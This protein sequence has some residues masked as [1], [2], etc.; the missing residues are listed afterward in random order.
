MRTQHLRRVGFLGVAMAMAVVIAMASAPAAWAEVIVYNQAAHANSRT[1]EGPGGGTQNFSFGL[2]AGGGG[3]QNGFAGIA[4]FQLPDVLTASNVQSADLQFTLSALGNNVLGNLDIYG[5]GF[6]HGT[7]STTVPSSWYFD[8]ANDTRTGTVLGTNIGANQ[9]TKIADNALPGGATNAS[10]SVHNTGPGQD[11]TLATFLRSLYTAGA[12]G[13]DYAIIRFN[14]DNYVQHAGNQNR[15]N[16]G[17]TTS[18]ATPP[19]EVAVLTINTDT[20]TLIDHNNIT[21]VASSQWTTTTPNRLASQAVD[22]SGLSGPVLK[23]ALHAGSPAT[24][25]LSGNG[26]VPADQWFRVD[27]GDVY[28]ME[29]MK[30]FND[31]LTTRQVTQADIYTAISAFD[32]GGDPGNPDDNPGNWVL[33]FSNRAFAPYTNNTDSTD[34]LDLSGITARYVALSIDANGGDGLVG[35]GEL[36]FFGTVAIP[37]PSTAL[38]AVTGI[39]ALAH[40]RSRR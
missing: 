27:L 13:G 15:Y 6:L 32:H 12:V 21:A 23:G 20:P 16:I 34:I 37:E 2:L 36:Q 7:P 25:W 39:M 5:L 9:V 1:I 26:T 10:P 28:K 29:A 19:S 38:L 18:G 8:G 3:G 14:V 4:Y 40:R 17:S 33:Q 35:L 11:A 31:G 30:T 24:V 22:G